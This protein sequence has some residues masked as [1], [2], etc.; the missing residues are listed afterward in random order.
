[1]TLHAAVQT[2]GEV[3]VTRRHHPALSEVFNCPV[4]PCA[5]RRRPGETIPA[6][7]SDDE[8]GKGE[9][10]LEGAHREREEWVLQRAAGELG[11]G[12]LLVDVLASRLGAAPSASVFTTTN[13]EHPRVYM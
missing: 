9:G 3:F 12:P 6:S 4:I 2:A 8:T 10:T 7:D 13:V 5:V 11:A 1:M